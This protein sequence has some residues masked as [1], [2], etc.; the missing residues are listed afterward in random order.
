MSAG[1][2]L[3]VIPLG[4]SFVDA[5]ARSLLAQ[6]GDDPMALARHLILLPNRR[7]VRALGE[8]FLRAAEGRA[9][10]MP[11]IGA[12]GDL[13][14]GELFGLEGPEALD[15]PPAMAETERLVILAELV[16][17]AGSAEIGARSPAAAIGLARS[18]A[19]LIDMLHVERV[20]ASRLCTLVPDIFA[21]HWQ[22]TLDFLDIVLRVWPDILEKSGRIDAADRRNRLLDAL[23]RRWRAA[24]PDRPVIA[25]GTTGSIPATA[26]LLAT[27]AH[28][29]QGAV[30]LPGFDRTHDE[31]RDGKLDPTHP[32]YQMAALVRHLGAVPADIRDWPLTDEDQAQ[33][34]AMAPRV[35]LLRAALRPAS[36]FGTPLSEDML[37]ADALS[38]CERVAFETER[39]EAVALALLLRE[40]LETPGRRAALVTP[41]RTLARQVKA[42]LLRY[43]IEI[44]DSAGLPLSE[45]VPGSFLR[46]LLAAGADRFGPVSILALL[47]HPLAA[48]GMSPARLRR[49]MRIVDVQSSRDGDALRG[50]RPAPG[51][52]GLRDAARVAG[53]KPEP[54]ADYERCLRLLEPLAAL[55]DSKE[56]TLKKALECLVA[57]AEA[58]SEDDKATG[59]ERL[60]R[61]EAGEA[62]ARH[63]REI[64]DAAGMTTPFAPDEFPALFDAL[65]EGVVVRPRFG[66]HPRL[67]ILGPIEARL[68]HDDLMLLGGLNE[69]IWPPAPPHDPWMSRSMRQS[70]GLSSEDRR[71]GQS[72][73]DFLAAA[74]AP[75]SVLSRAGKSDGVPTL[76][77]RWLTRIE[78]LAGR[79]HAAGLR[80]KRLMQ[81][82]DRP[83]APVVTPPPAPCPPA[84]AR[85][86]SLSVTDIERLMRD[87]YSLYARRILRLE[88]LAELEEPPGAAAR[89]SAIHLA[90][91]LYV[92]RRMPEMTEAE[93]LALLTDVGRTAFGT[94]LDRPGVRAFWWPR[95]LRIARRFLEIE[96]EREAD[97]AILATEIR[98]N[99]VLS[100]LDGFRIV[101]KADRIDRMRASGRLV[102][103]D[104]KTG[105][106]PGNKQ[107]A[108]GFAPQLPLEGWMA[109]EG[110]F[111][112]IE[113]AEIE[114]LEY[115]HLKGTRTPIDIRK[116]PDCDMRI[117]EAREGAKAL[118]A[119]FRDPGTPFLSRPNPRFGGL[120]DYDHL[121]RAAE[122][123]MTGDGE[124]EE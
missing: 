91:D 83:V 68:Q 28:L 122:W 108:A 87:P 36:A 13:D 37:R 66:R 103:I 47:R 42:E 21:R 88:P 11:R 22:K 100:D 63:L 95:Y 114:G 35:A 30:I 98:G 69:G 111:S 53:L 112:G 43:G 89:G 96:K 94:L 48:A 61:G 120:D 27:I 70:L 85:P 40:A 8:A 106:P 9:I 17:A 3:F 19:G 25:A 60:W 20:E 57:V 15:I 124:G 109:M 123:N 80:L 54:L 115:W 34:A 1:P 50:P 2:H 104:Y 16:R 110:A 23:A 86:V 101:A 90:L 92:R 4:L 38:G 7:S 67:R 107:I 119:R 84:S 113:R 24:P 82:L 97:H 31:A 72:A 118:I 64:A 45:T 55:F 76:E 77:S 105:A 32:D 78:A 99:L 117:E 6:A 52:E 73:H 65:L 81:H 10:L 121:A 26:T 49:L 75:T 41:S 74:A 46:L 102:I 79:S 59:A 116:V 71:I 62:L 33:A 14:E 12:L 44:D 5:L 29:P 56:I 18:L 39:E 51:L 58:L 93:R